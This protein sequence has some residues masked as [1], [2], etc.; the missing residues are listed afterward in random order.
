MI[1]P[2]ERYTVNHPKGLVCC[3]LGVAELKLEHYFAL[4]EDGKIHVSANDSISAFGGG[5]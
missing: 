2:R 3:K 1:R 5:G 4:T